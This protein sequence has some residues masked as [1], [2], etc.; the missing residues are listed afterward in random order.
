MNRWFV[1]AASALGL[2]KFWITPFI[3]V[4]GSVPS[5]RVL[6][7]RLEPFTASG[8]P[9]CVQIIGNAPDPFAECAERLLELGFRRVNLNFACPSPTVLKSRSGSKMLENPELLERCV[10]AVK[11]V[12]PGNVSLSVK[13]RAGFKTDRTE[14][15]VKAS[16]SGGAEWIIFHFRTGK[17]MYSEV[18]GREER[19]SRAVRA[20]GT[21]PVYGNGDLRSRAEAELLMRE[22]GCAG[23]VAARG[24][25]RNPAIFLDRFPGDAQAGFVSAMRKLGAPE[26]TLRKFRRLGGTV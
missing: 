8:L 17:E 11:S 9:I 10:S 22:T 26:S 21:V 3:S 25:L 6:R 5:K 2:V 20:A 24:F 14:D 15:V 13:L 7:K 1:S 18:P 16:C 23:A 19:I 4:S 12:L